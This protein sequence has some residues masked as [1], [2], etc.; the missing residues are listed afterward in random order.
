MS[1]NNNALV[2]SLFLKYLLKCLLNVNTYPISSDI[3]FAKLKV[4]DAGNLH[5][6]SYC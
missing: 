5:V 1:F 3:L 4:S 6:D 2:I